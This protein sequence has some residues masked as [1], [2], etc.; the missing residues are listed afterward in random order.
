MNWNFNL[1][2]VFGLFNPGISGLLWYLFQQVTK[3]ISFINFKET[4]YLSSM[5]YTF[6]LFSFYR[7][8]LRHS[9]FFF[10]CWEKKNFETHRYMTLTILFHV[11]DIPFLV[12]SHFIRG[13]YKIFFL[14]TNFY[15]GWIL[16]INFRI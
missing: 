11:I 4:V 7:I 6:R 1:I 2:Q 3:Y 13:H 12:W 10:S 15:Y 16:S 9:H 5:C 14:L 8:V